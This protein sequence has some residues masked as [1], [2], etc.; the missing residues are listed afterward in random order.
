MIK[1]EKFLKMVSS[2]VK[3]FDSGADVILFGSRARKDALEESDWDFLILLEAEVTDELKS[4]I[5]KQ[6]Y[7][8][9]LQND[10]VVSSIFY[11]KKEWNSDIIKATPLY[12]NIENEGVLI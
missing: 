11:T 1:V 3:Q 2:A 7:E 5:R 12:K 10:I 9:E 6:L 8:I 4:K